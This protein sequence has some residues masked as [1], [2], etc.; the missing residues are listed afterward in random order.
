[1]VLL[2]L[3]ENNVPQFR[4][5]NFELAFAA[6]F[7]PNNRGSL[8]KLSTV[9]LGGLQPMVPR[10]PGQS[11]AGPIQ[12][13]IVPVVV[14]RARSMS[15]SSPVSRSGNGL[16]VQQNWMSPANLN[17]EMMMNNIYI[18]YYKI[19]VGGWFLSE[20]FRRN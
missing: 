18:K 4:H 7:M 1:M 9:Q 8:A 13:A 14:K 5:P 17:G 19:L 3:F 12:S 6:R 16:K 2:A 11:T 20:H 15:P 10:S